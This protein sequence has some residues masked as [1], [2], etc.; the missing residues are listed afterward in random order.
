[1]RLFL[2]RLRNRF[3]LEKQKKKKGIWVYLFSVYG[4]RVP[5]LWLKCRIAPEMSLMLFLRSP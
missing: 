4:V 5:F 3:E 2:D 1:M